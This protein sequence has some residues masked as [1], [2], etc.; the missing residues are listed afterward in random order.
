MPTIV[1]V[2]VQAG[3][4]KTLV[5]AVQ[6]A[7][8]VDTLSGPGPFT[9]FAPTDEAFNKLPPGTVEALL[10]DIPKLKNILLY[11]VIAG[12]IMADDAAKLTSAKT[13]QGQDIMIDA[14]NKNE[15]GRNDPAFDRDSVHWHRY[16]QINDTSYVVKANVLA[17][18]GV[19]HVVN[20][21]LLPK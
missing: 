1:D 5:A 11:H 21:V 6:A 2:A 20:A 19:I 3:T 17:D 16:L 15:L 13:V 7:G 9:V 12:K 8:L 14:S 4:F 18:N 10:K